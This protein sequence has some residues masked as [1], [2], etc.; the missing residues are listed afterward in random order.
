MMIR[1]L[2]IMAGALGGDPSPVQAVSP[3]DTWQR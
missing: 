1:N 3:E 2:T